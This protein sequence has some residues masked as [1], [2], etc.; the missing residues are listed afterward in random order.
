[1][2]SSIESRAW[3]IDSSDVWE[4]VYFNFL[5]DL[6]LWLDEQWPKAEAIG[7]KGQSTLKGALTQGALASFALSARRFSSGLPGVELASPPY[8]ET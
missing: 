5:G 3:Q 6:A 8:P 4:G 1:M 2:D 7:L